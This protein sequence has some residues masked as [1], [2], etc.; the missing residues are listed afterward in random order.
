MSASGIGGAFV[1]S[2]SRRGTNGLP[3][4]AVGMGFDPNR[5]HRRLMVRLRTEPHRP[6]NRT[7]VGV[8]VRTE[9]QRDR[10]V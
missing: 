1:A 9:R 5:R 6:P 10:A 4:D 3:F 2:S 8:A 7:V